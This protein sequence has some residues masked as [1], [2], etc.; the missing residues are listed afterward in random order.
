M[1]SEE[2]QAVSKLVADIVAEEREVFSKLV[3]D[4]VE[5]LLAKRERELE[6]GLAKV[7][8]FIDEMQVL[9][10]RLRQIDSAAHDARVDSVKMN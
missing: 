5:R 10:E 6:Q 2:R 3:T 1:T 7:Q 8:R 4:G 9:V